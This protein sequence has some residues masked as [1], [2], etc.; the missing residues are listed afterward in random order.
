MAAAALLSSIGVTGA[1]APVTLAHGQLYKVTAGAANLQ[2]PL[3]TAIFANDGKGPGGPNQ[4]SSL[5]RYCH[6][7]QHP[8]GLNLFT[9][10]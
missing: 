5:S 9:V 4:F 2:L 1:K 6:T 10:F 8:R 3:N 7:N